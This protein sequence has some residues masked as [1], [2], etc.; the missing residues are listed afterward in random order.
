M[1]AAVSSIMTPAEKL[2]TVSEGTSQEEV[3]KLMYENRIEK[4]LVTR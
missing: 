1:D 3:K 4:I 2:I